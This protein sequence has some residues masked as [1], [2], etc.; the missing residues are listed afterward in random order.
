MLEF[1]FPECSFLILRKKMA[2]EILINCIKP[3]TKFHITY[4]SYKSPQLGYYFLIA[5]DQTGKICFITSYQ[6]ETE[7]LAISKLQ[8]TWPN[9]TLTKDNGSIEPLAKK[10]FATE[11]AGRFEVVVRGTDMEVEVW[12]QLTKI[13]AGS[14]A[15]YED[16]A[17]AIGR[18]KAARAVGN[19]VAR[20][21]VLRLI[22]CH[23]VVH[24]NGKVN[25]FSGGVDLKRALLGME[26]VKI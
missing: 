9:A 21:Q 2:S 24:K 4:G 11:P 16:I 19:A 6:G 17:R 3:K 22:P 20:N 7:S 14:T 12:K 1:L 18:P 26:G 15:S 8:T 13:K 25:K 23:R 5:T 10:L